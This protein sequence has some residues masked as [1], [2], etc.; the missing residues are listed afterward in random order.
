M[1]TGIQ[2]WGQAFMTSLAAALALFLAAIPRIIGFL[3]VIIIGWF[4]A[5]A[6]AKAVGAI[7]RR[8]DFDGLASRSGFTSFVHKTGVQTDASGF[9]AAVAKWFI[10]L[11]VLVVAFDVL[12]LP[13]VSAVLHELLLWLP[14]LAVALVVLVIGGL[15][16][17]AVSGLVRGATAEADLGNPDL[18]AKLA[19]AAIWAFAIIVAVNQL[20]IATT[21]VNTLFM[22][23]VFALALALGLAFG[24]GG[25]ETVA[26]IVRKWYIRGQ[27]NAPKMAE[28]MAT[29]RDQARAREHEREPPPQPVQKPITKETGGTSIEVEPKG[30]RD[31][32]S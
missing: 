20:G 23:T 11:I 22:A 4:I 15:A 19:S 21:L 10:R 30:R 14:N 1:Q 31:D 16:A 26:E 7:L 3:L 32:L 13:A 9:I 8:V 12:G 18:L 24:L 2:D 29:A 28:A 25:R 17:Q 5:T 6:L 27:Q